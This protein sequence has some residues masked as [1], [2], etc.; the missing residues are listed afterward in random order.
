MEGL[1]TF[2]DIILNR[3]LDISEEIEDTGLSILVLSRSLGCVYC[4]DCSAWKYK[5]GKCEYSNN[6]DQRVFV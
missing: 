2:I 4:T 1:E 6:R 3:S 5:E